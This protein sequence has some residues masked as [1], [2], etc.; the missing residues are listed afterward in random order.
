MTD[1]KKILTKD[2]VFSHKGLYIST[3][4]P[5]V[6]S[7]PHIGHA[8][9]FVLA[10]FLKR[11][12]NFLQQKKEENNRVYPTHNVSTNSYQNKYGKFNLPYCTLNTGIDEHGQK[13]YQR[14]IELNK[15]PQQFCDEMADTW[16]DFCKII[17][18]DYDN[19][20]RTSSDAHK[21]NAQEYLFKIRNL[22]YK[23]Q[24]TGNYCQGCESIKTDKEI[25]N[26]QCEFH[27]G[28]KLMQI[29]E[30]NFFFPLTNFKDMDL[31]NILVDKTFQ[32]ELNSI[33]QNCGDLSIS[34]ENVNWGIDIPFS[35]QK[36]YVWFEALLN[37]VFA[38]G[39]TTSLVNFFEFSENWKN[40]LII[41]GKDNLKFQAY[42]LPALLKA[43]Y[44]NPPKKVLVHGM[45]L[46]SNKLKMSKSI[47]NVVDPI[48]QFKKYGSNAVRYY[49]LSGLNTFQDSSYS[50]EVLVTKYN[51]DL[52]NNYGNLIARVTTIL[53]QDQRLNLTKNTIIDGPSEIFN[54][55]FSEYDNLNS[56]SQFIIYVK[57]EIE[58]AHNQLEENLNVKE[59]FSI[60]N[61][62]INYTN[63]YF[64]TEK[65][66]DVNS[67]NRNQVLLETLFVVR[68]TSIFYMA[69][70]PE[71]GDFLSNHLTKRIIKTILYKKIE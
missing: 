30:E 39:Y 58:K 69:A 65:P 8:F 70:T 10:D 23:K 67:I 53:E 32:N 52:V 35:N 45:I 40:S 20:Y 34:R 33:V 17:F 49:L 27:V 38:I 15:E 28:T 37:Y 47:G 61:N 57:T 54:F 68:E 43:N 46:D 4:L 6:N 22:I 13:I 64:T 2:S 41:C 59:C 42:I 55:N 51:S 60:I 21:K 1:D 50:E 63:K 3:T 19:F 16:K 7:Q 62:L 14:A 18:M 56:D 71:I 25:I 11:Y 5:Y 12:Y 66:Y 24:Y 31:S 44:I 36:M 9:E 26:N 48:E 29:S